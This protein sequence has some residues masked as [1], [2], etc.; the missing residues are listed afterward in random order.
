MTLSKVNRTEEVVPTL[1]SG[2]STTNKAWFWPKI[3]PGKITLKIARSA[4]SG[5]PTAG[6]LV[7]NHSIF[8]KWPWIKLL[9][10]KR[11]FL[12]HTQAPRP[13]IQP[14]LA[15]KPRQNHPQ[16]SMFRSVRGSDSCYIGNQS[17]YFHSMTLS[18]DIRAQEGVPTSHTGSRTTNKAWIG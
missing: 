14:E 10:L 6:S 3:R 7:T 2:S 9:E 17:L 11:G 1:Q 12:H 5:D 15:K 8:N 18:K 4:L 13:Q 16:N